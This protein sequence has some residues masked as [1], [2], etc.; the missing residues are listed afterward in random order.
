MI[1]LVDQIE[2]SL[3][4]LRKL[5]T[6]EIIG[7]V[8]REARKE[9]LPYRR[10]AVEV[11]G[12]VAEAFQSD[13]FS[14]IYEMLEPLFEPKDGEMEED[15]EEQE[16]GQQLQ[17]LELHEAAVMAL[18]RAFPTDPTAQGLSFIILANDPG[19]FIF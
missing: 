17:R 1:L 19:S 8:L 2:L 15:G 18:G 11:L 14:A 10:H 12:Q 4:S 9:A 13:L 3:Y 7:V 5:L 16:E 6:D